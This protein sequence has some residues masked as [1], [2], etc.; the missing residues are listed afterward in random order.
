M[1]DSVVKDES[2]KF[3][4]RIVRLCKE[5][6]EKKEY[7]LSSDSLPKSPKR[8]NKTTDCSTNYRLSTVDYQLLL[9]CRQ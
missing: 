3:A 8:P 5:P 7:V 1:A 2:Y 4:I 9:W 6:D